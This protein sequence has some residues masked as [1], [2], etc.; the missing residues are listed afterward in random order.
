[1]DQANKDQ[2]K[3]YFNHTDKEDEKVTL[4]AF[5]KSKN[6]NDLRQIAEEQWEKSSSEKIDLQHVLKRVHTYINSKRQKENREYKF[7]QTYYKVAA[8]LVLP[9]LTGSLYLSIQSYNQGAKFTE[10]SA[11]SGS[12]VHFSLP[13]GSTGY[14]NGGSILKYSMKF[15]K[16]RDISLSGEGYFEVKKD[17]KRP[18]TVQTQHANIEVLGTKFDICSYED[19]HEVITTLEEGSVQIINKVNQQKTMLKPGEQNRLNKQTGTMTNSEVDTHLY[20]SWKE[21]I[22]RFDNATFTEVVKK[23]ERWYGVSIKLDKK[24]S[25]EENYTLAIKTESLREMLQLLAVTA[26]IDY[27]ITED[28][29]EIFQIKN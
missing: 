6:D 3:G 19:D 11:P 5:L 26:P 7:L 10:I 22:L 8:I 27:K 24:L 4:E 29:V 15:D 21:Q 13:D 12:R 1:M 20:T 9:L 23:M 16:N 17:N 2:I 25:D 14:L 28:Q 18:F